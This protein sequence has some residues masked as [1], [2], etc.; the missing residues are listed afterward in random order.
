MIDIS[1]ETRETAAQLC[2]SMA[3]RAATHEHNSTWFVPSCEALGVDYRDE[4]GAA[5]LA[6]LAFFQ[7]ATSALGG[8]EC[9]ALAC[10]MLRTEWTP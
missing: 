6:R 3:T 5:E 8:V 9:W 7:A 4:N 1:A 10:S 2:S